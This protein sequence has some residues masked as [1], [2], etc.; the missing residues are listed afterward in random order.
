M[1]S[2]GTVPNLTSSADISP[3]RMV[4]VSGIMTGAAATA[5][6]DVVIG[7]TDGSVSTYNGTYNAPSG[8]VINFQQG[9]CVQ[10]EAGG[11]ISAGG[12][13]MPTTGGKGLAATGTGKYGSYVALQTAAADGE[14]IWA[15]SRP[16]P[17][18]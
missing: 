13:I 16:G 7:V 2:D 6:T 10:I 14:V 3:Y 15:F 18:L 5:G 17:T 9:P 11:A 4:K 8:S 1:A 12:S